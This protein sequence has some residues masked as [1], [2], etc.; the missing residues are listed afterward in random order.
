MEPERGLSDGFRT[1]LTLD[2]GMYRVGD[3]LWL[4]FEISDQRFHRLPQTADWYLARVAEQAIEK[5]RDAGREFEYLGKQT[6][7]TADKLMVEGC[8][9]F[10]YPGDY[11]RCCQ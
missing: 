6:R 3:L 2:T 1:T 11:E 5:S 4:E 8:L 7:R 10:G 9:V